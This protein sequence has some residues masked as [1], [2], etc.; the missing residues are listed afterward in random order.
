M[1]CKRHHIVRHVLLPGV[2]PGIVGSSTLTVV[3]LVGV[4]T[5]TGVVGVGGLGGTAIRYGYQ[6]F[7]ATVTAVAVVVLIG[8][9]SFV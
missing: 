5:M 2:L 3:S 7:D 9:V 4:S 6:R 8:L 1:G